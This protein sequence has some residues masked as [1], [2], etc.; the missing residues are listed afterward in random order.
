MGLQ[1]LRLDQ[2]KKYELALATRSIVEMVIALLGRREHFVAVGTERGD[3]GEWDDIVIQKKDGVQQHIQVKRQNVDFCTK[4][5]QRVGD[6]KKDLSVIDKALLNLAKWVSENDRPE[7]LRSKRFTLEVENP[8]AK[9]KKGIEVRHFASFCNEEL[10]RGTTKEGLEE[11]ELQEGS[12][13]KDIRQWLCSW[14]G[15]QDWTHILKGL[16]L[17]DVKSSG[18]VGDIED[19]T[20]RMLLSSGLF[21]DIPRVRCAIRELCFENSSFSSALTPIL[22]LDQVKD[23]LLPEYRKWTQYRYNGPKCEISGINQLD[24]D[25]VESANSVVPAVWNPDIRSDLY[26]SA[27]DRMSGLLLPKS[28]LRLA[29]HLQGAPSGAYIVNS[30]FWRRHAYN[31]LGGTL[32]KSKNDLDNAQLA[33]LE[34]T[35][36]CNPPF[37]RALDTVTLANSEAQRL[38]N[39][40]TL[41]T[42][43]MINGSVFLRI[44]K[45]PQGTL[46][47]AIDSRWNKWKEHFDSDLPRRREF[48]LSLVNPK[49]EARIVEPELRIGPKMVD[50]MAEAILLLLMISVSLGGSDTQWNALE[51][52][53]DIS[54]IALKF[55]GGKSGI[56]PVDIEDLDT[57]E[58]LVGRE[59]PNILVLSGTSMLSDSISGPTLAHEDRQDMTLI[60]PHKPTIV[61]T[62]NKK[63]KALIRS[64]SID[65]MRGWLTNELE[66]NGIIREVL[67]QEICDEARDHNRKAI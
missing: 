50:L 23:F 41:Y 44:S 63:F 43:E 18:G 22:V 37:Q 62:N 36:P 6:D 59:N 5:S 28:I 39:E 21:R 42:W 58:S 40:M 61:I 3:L 2:T 13:A 66:N 46:M 15:F 65:Q 9:L 16:S 48:L 64:G 38:H 67:I 19:E 8:Q 25:L 29:L 51:G 54:A 10:Q 12:N 11:L 26:F 57:V 30:S 14:C 17:L 27:P 33:V 7:L 31:L 56:G 53:L 52:G 20:E 49:A 55:W 24:S 47:D 32:G 45:L 35:A 4:D 34:D 60:A 1:K